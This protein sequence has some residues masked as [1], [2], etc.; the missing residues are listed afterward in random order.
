MTD[1]TKDNVSI[2]D[3]DGKKIKVIKPTSK[4]RRESDAIYAKAYREAISNGYFLEAEI[5]TILKNR[6]LDRES[7]SEQLEMTGRLIDKKISL[8][9]DDLSIEEGVVIIEEISILRKS[10]DEVDSARYELNSQSA[11]LAAENKR[12]NFFCFSCSS[13]ENGGLLWSS[14][15]EFEEQESE[16]GVQ[17]ISEMIKFLY[18]G[19]KEMVK[20]IEDLRGENVWLKAKSLPVSQSPLTE[21]ATKQAKT[22]KVVNYSK[23]RQ[24]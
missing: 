20:K 18:S 9:T 6:G 11:S 22:T 16:V 2:L 1:F 14:M 7:M 13:L 8:L 24:A 5:E 12:F 21:K 3:V 4:I 19:T 23:K 10:A 17:V 15:K